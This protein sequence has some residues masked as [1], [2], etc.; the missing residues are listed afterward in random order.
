MQYKVIYNKQ[1]NV[2]EHKFKVKNKNYNYVL[3]HIC[4]IN[5]IDKIHKIISSNLESLYE[6]FLEFIPKSLDDDIGDGFMFM[7][8]MNEKFYLC[9]ITKL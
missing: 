6:S 2:L 5:N 3:S 1:N 7:K 9:K 8:F 4:Y